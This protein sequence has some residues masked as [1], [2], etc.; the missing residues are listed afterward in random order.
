MR[1]VTIGPAVRATW[2]T[3]EEKWVVQRQYGKA[4]KTVLSIYRGGYH[5]HKRNADGLVLSELVRHRPE[6]LDGVTKE[7]RDT[8]YVGAM[9]LVGRQVHKNSHGSVETI[10]RALERAS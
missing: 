10:R 4:W 1:R 8:Y 5:E 6:L 3:E 9:L 2:D 7:G